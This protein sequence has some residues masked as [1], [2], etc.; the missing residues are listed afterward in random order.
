MYR[1]LYKLGHEMQVG[2]TQ[3]QRIEVDSKTFEQLLPKPRQ[4]VRTPCLLIHNC[5]LV[6]HRVSFSF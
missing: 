5:K 6:S 3:E 4:K 2:L 1:V